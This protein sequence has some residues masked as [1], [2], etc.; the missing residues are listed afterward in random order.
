METIRVTAAE[1][2]RIGQAAAGTGTNKQRFCLAAIMGAVE[3][4]EDRPIPSHCVRLHPFQQ[5]AIDMPP[6]PEFIKSTYEVSQYQAGGQWY[7]K[8]ERANVICA[9]EDAQMQ[10][11]LP[12]P[13]L[14]HTLTN[15]S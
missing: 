2:R 11:F 13:D 7:F 10:K 15:A 8:D 5:P 1:Q 12:N 6:P 4:W 14:E 3:R 9:W